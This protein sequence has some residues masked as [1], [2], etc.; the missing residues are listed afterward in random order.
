[1]SSCT[2]YRGSKCNNNISTKSFACQ[3]GSIWIIVTHRNRKWQYCYRIRIYSIPHSLRNICNPHPPSPK[4]ILGD[5]HQIKEVFDSCSWTLRMLINA[6]TESIFF[7][8]HH[9]KGEQMCLFNTFTN[10][11]SHSKTWVK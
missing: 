1:M 9:R 4:N 3:T 6:E 11:Y 2:L 5:S 10:K 7:K 8:I